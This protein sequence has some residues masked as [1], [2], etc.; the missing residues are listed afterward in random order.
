[1]RVTRP[2]VSAEESPMMRHMCSMISPTSAYPGSA[3]A[4]PSVQVSAPEA[5]IAFQISRSR[6]WRIASSLPPMLAAGPKRLA[7][8]NLLGP[9]A[10][11]GGNELAMRHGR[12]RLIWKAMLASGALTCTLGFAAALPGYALVGLIMLHMCLIMGDS[13]ALTAGLVTRIDEARGQ[14]GGIAH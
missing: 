9:A 8:A 2:A 14:R 11:I 13:S 6:P 5:S 3:A 12:E 10:S 7:I 1:M 4:K